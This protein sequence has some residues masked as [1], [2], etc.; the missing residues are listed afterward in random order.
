[1]DWDK[2]TTNIYTQ[3]EPREEKIPVNGTE[4]HDLIAKQP[5]FCDWKPTMC[6]CSSFTTFNDEHT[7]YYLDSFW[8]FSHMILRFSFA[9]SQLNV[10]DMPPAKFGNR[11]IYCTF[12][13]RPSYHLVHGAYGSCF[14]LSVHY[15]H[16][17]HPPIIPNHSLYYFNIHTCVVSKACLGSRRR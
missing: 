6:L 12:R 5:Q 2:H 1:M 7:V 8:I 15:C 16:P 3:T 10:S 4:G 17:R 11:G 9:T 13:C 14:P